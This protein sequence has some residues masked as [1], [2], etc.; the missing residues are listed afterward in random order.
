MSILDLSCRESVCTRKEGC[1]VFGCMETLQ[2]GLEY[3]IYLSF[4]LPPDYY[5]KYLE[6]AK[7]VLFKI[8]T[9]CMTSEE[10]EEESYEIYPLLDYFSTYPCFY[11]PP[12]VDEERKVQ[13]IDSEHCS[14]SEA[15]ITSLVKAWLNH[16]IE[17]KG[18]ML[19]GSEAERV[20]TYASDC[21][22]RKGM[23]PM[24]R[25]IYEDNCTCTPLTTVA[26]TVKMNE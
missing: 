1:N 7:L 5:I 3:Q 4:D 23:R 13:L 21:Y 25:L 6:Q 24:L 26:C 17:N 8:P 10:T 12:A 20:I 2:L 18:L 11:D 9:K 15:D 14:Y 16:E 22:E 19:T